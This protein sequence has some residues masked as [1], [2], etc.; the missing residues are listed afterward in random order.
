MNPLFIFIS[1]FTVFSCP[2]I[3]FSKR[4]T[5]EFKIWENK[6]YKK[7]IETVLIHKKGWELSM[8]IIELGKEDM[9]SLQFD[10]IGTKVND[11]SWTIV[12]CNSKWQESDL[13]PIEYIEGYQELEVE[14]YSFSQNTLVNYANY[15]IEFPND[16]MQMTISGNYIIKIY[17]RDEPEKLILVRR[18]YVVENQVKVD[19]KVDNLNVKVNEG[20][21][22]RLNIEL[23]C[24]YE[25]ENPYE[26]VMLKVQKNNGI[27]KDF[28][29][30]KPSFID[31]N[32]LKYIAVNELAFAG[33][34]EYRHF[35]IK[36][37]KFISDRLLTVDKQMDINYVYLRPDN[38]KSLETYD[39][40]HDINGKRTV[41]LENNSTSDIMADYCYVYFQ[42][43]AEIPLQHGDYYIYGA[44]TDWIY[45]NAAKME[46]D[47]KSGKFIGRLYLKQGYY[48]YQYRFITDDKMLNTEEYSYTIEGNYFQTE[49][50][51][52]IFVYYKDYGTSYEKLVGYTRVNSTRKT[53]Y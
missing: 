12:H 34:N 32:V 1:F 4:N 33:G 41:K 47:S 27:V 21:N 39:F 7:G 28:S 9:I 42:L 40:K 2:D 45:N 16:D 20:L 24:D 48:N 49:N 6:I 8:P 50:D 18:F 15:S 19:A 5:P 25:I 3:N 10:E 35:D 13:N 31:G 37:F 36:N 17:D 30:I 46:Y 52:H 38:D 11:Y 23:K 14:S 43:D 26:T 29:K 22:Q 53:N 51:F 44:L